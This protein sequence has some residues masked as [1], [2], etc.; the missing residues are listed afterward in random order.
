MNVS[1]E[2]VSLS[3][4]DRQSPVSFTHTLLCV[5]SSEDLREELE[6]EEKGTMIALILR[7]S[8]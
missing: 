3:W 1:E 5:S 8:P 2:V 4:P 7:A 6:K